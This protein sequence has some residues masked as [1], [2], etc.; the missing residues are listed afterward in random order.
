MND[1]S[2][3]AQEIAAHTRRLLTTG[4][5]KSFSYADIADVVQI[6]KASI[7]HH[8]PGKADLVRTVVAQYR[9]EA[10]AGMAALDHQLNDALAEIKAYVDYWSH[11]IKDGT[12]SFCICVML[13]VELPTLPAEVA[14]EVTGHFQELVEWLTSLLEK[15][16]NEGVI[17]LKDTPVVEARALMATVHGAM[18]AARAFDNADIFQEIMQPVLNRLLGS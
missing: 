14:I 1:L 13:A 8:F 9:E 17:E 11:C 4:G 3:K 7:H 2:Q 16:Q 6:R 15:G 10:R 18:L 12:S 5:Y